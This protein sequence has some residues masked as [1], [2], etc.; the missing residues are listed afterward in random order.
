[1]KL[2]KSSTGGVTILDFI[3]NYRAMVIKNSMVL[4][5]KQT[6]RPMEHN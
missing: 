1:M 5:P 2:E 4:E 6:R 3:P